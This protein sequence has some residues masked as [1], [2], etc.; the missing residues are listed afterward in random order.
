MIGLPWLTVTFAGSAGMAICF[1]LFFALNPAYAA[2]CGAY[3]GKNIKR[4]WALPILTAI[5]FLAGV[6]M[7]FEMGET[8]FLLYFCC[9]L[10]IGIIAMLI[11][12]IINKTKQ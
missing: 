1:L 12:A 3:A 4:L 2:V 7:F 9:Y 6:W 8:A 5:L 11:S 10:I